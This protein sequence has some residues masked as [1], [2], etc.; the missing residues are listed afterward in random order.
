MKSDTKPLFRDHF[1]DYVEGY[2]H[3]SFDSQTDVTRSKLMARYFAEKV[4]APRN[5]TLLPFGEEELSLCVIDGKGDQGVDFI[6][7]EGDTVL[8]IQAKYSG[9]KKA[10]KR[11][12]EDPADFEY[13]RQVLRRLRDYR[14][15]QMAQPLREVC[16]DIDWDRDRFLLHYI[17]LR[18]L[19]GNQE[20]LAAKPLSNPTNISDLLDRVEMSLLDE[21][22]LN[23]E[24]RDTLSLD[25]QTPEPISLRFTP[26]AEGGAWLRL[27]DQNTDRSCYLG[28]VSGAQLSHLFTRYKSRLF[29]L[30]IRN[31]LGDNV[32]NRGI[33]ATATENPNAFFFFNNGISALATRIEK[34]PADPLEIT[35]NCENLSIINGAQTIRALNKAQIE[36]P[37]SVREVQ[38]LFRIT[39]FS[40]K[41]TTVEQEFLDNVTKYN[42]TQTTIRLSDFRS[43]D[44][45][46]YDL[47]N[48]FWNLPAVDGKK[49]LYKNKRSGEREAGRSI[50][51][52]EFIKTIFA[53]LFGPDDMFGG[54]AYVF[55]ATRDGGYTR[56]FGD[57]GEIL[58]ALDNRTFEF[59]AG[60]WFLCN[61]AR[62]GWKNRSAQSKE[63]ALERRWMFYFALG[64]ALR[65]AYEDQDTLLQA[66]VVALGDPRWSRPE[67]GK[68]TKRAID[69][70]SKL[71]FKSLSDAYRTASSQQGFT[72]R[73]WFRDK[74]T[75]AEVRERIRSSWE[76]ISEHAEDYRLTKRRANP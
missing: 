35:L 10:S 17:T 67:A 29:S 25:A 14:D 57:A 32:T 4:L 38:V 54:T 48:R 36:N 27:Y 34:D 44:K 65:V 68:D 3:E 39:E 75:L 73:N 11:P 13:F 19:E 45:V 33:R 69:N 53:F 50:G 18:Q 56:L 22:H 60:I 43:N 16:A 66:D 30:N 31:Y 52:E 26:N 15:L 70:G 51:M 76:L 61:Y 20:A 49:F 55:D 40:A 58:P 71:A 37:G 1:R 42:N 24:L 74:A 21:N 9:G 12:Y 5:P 46:Q 28:R 59:Y 63:P 41:K 7:R 72:H 47:R 62:E 6:S 23:L 8:I 64:E 2:L